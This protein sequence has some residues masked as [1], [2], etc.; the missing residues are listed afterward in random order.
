M[1]S[2]RNT[3]KNVK[4]EN[5]I[6]LTSFVR[7]CRLQIKSDQLNLISK[8]LRTNA[9]NALSSEGYNYNTPKGVIADRFFLPSSKW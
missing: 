7:L 8:Q 5:T 1:L 3:Y 9:M 6:S 2:G 4:L